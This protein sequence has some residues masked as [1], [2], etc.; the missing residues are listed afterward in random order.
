VSESDQGSPAARL[1]DRLRAAQSAA[2]S[3]RRVEA[4]RLGDAM[5]LVIDRLATS[6]APLDRLAEAADQLEAIAA[7]LADSPKRRMYDGFAESANAGDAHA[8]FDWSPF[9]GRSNALAPPIVVDADDGRIVGRVRFGSAYEGPPGCVHGGFIAAG[10]DEV[11]G[12][13]NSMSGVPAMTANLTVRYR[14]PTPLH[15]ELRY[16]GT[17]LS[18]S[19]RK[20]KTHGELWAGDILTAEAE[21]LFVRVGMAKFVELMA[22]RQ[23]ADDATGG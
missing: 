14:Q 1:D 10:F 16:V 12:L 6:V 9:L 13:T 19:G 4:R 3:P 17:L 18:V 8:F 20:V 15:Q 21:G 5:R 2:P 11:L 7:I 23:K 22:A